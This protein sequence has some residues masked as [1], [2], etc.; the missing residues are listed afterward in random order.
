VYPERFAVG[1]INGDGNPDIIVTNAHVSSGEANGELRIVLGNGDGTFRPAQTHRFDKGI[2]DVVLADVNGDGRSD[3]IVANYQEAYVAVLVCNGDGTLQEGIRYAVEDFP[4]SIITADL[5]G[6]KK[7]D[8]VTANYGSGTLSIL[9]S[10]QHGG[11]VA[12]RLY[13]A[14]QYPSKVA[15]GDFNNDGHLDAVTANW[16]STNVSVFLSDGTGTLSLKATCGV[17]SYP[18][19]VAVG[20]FNRDR[21]LDIVTTNANGNSISV[22]TGNGDGTF[23]PE[24]RYPVGMWPSSVVVSDLNGDGWM[25]IVVTNRDVTP[26]ETDCTVSVLWN[27]QDGGFNSQSRLVTGS[28]P[29]SVAV[30]D[31]NRDGLRD[32]AVVN[33]GSQ[34]VSIFYNRGGQRFS[35]QRRY[36]VAS[37]PESLTVGDFNGDG[38]LD[39]VVA[40]SVG[41][42]FLLG[43]GDESFQTVEESSLPGS[44]FVV[45]ADINRD[46]HLDLVL[47][48]L[49]LMLG[50]GTGKFSLAG[51]YTV[52]ANA[53]A[54][55]DFDGDGW[56]DLAAS[57]SSG[58]VATL[59]NLL[60]IIDLGA[61][62][63]DLFSGFNATEMGST[64]LQ[65]TPVH[66]GFLTVLVGDVQV[67]G[68]VTLR[69]YDANPLAN[70]GAE[71]L[72]ETE[73]TS[74]RLEY[75]FV[76]GGRPYY[77]TLNG[78]DTDFSL[79]FVNLFGVKPLGEDGALVTIY[80]TDGDDTLELRPS[81][82]PQVVINGVLY[83]PHDIPASMTVQ[84]E[85]GAGY[86]VV[87]AYDGPG[88]D[89]FELRPGLLT[90][91][92]ETS[93]P[94]TLDA[95]MGFEQ[96]HVYATGG[97]QDTSRLY[98]KLSGGGVDVAVKLKSE[99][100]Y[101]HVK[102]IG[103]RM[104]HRVKLFEVVEAY[105]AGDN[106]QALFWDSTGDDLF[107][108]GYGSSRMIGPGYDVRAYNFPRVT[109]YASGGNDTAR[110]MDS[111]LKDEFQSKS[112][113]CELFD[114]VTGGSRY[115]VSVRA[116]DYVYAE[117]STA[118]SNRDAAKLWPTGGDDLVEISGNVLDFSVLQ[119][120]MPRLIRRV[121]G[122]ENAKLQPTA[123]SNDRVRLVEPV[124]MTVE[125]GT[126]WQVE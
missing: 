69:L 98:D 52:Q 15:V 113:K 57:V 63:D 27:D 1:D 18:S 74:T 70:P 80:G 83:S 111:V 38:N 73:G 115:R 58:Y 75:E 22:L 36:P 77:V 99:P 112:N 13:K 41:L 103:A 3:A 7:L 37:R 102:M 90:G 43:N 66:D 2:R 30:G 16:E 76:E 45:S 26:Y 93:V 10:D 126:G 6:D 95:V 108:G 109:A 59:I 107:E 49:R 28:M 72:A 117:A 120:G 9:I 39:V 55:G 65:V 64:V 92:L 89:L 51:K 71:P 44:S 94:I 122:F 4:S 82:T 104:Y 87:T 100:E 32:L 23:Q 88:N 79:R 48:G 119:T 106:D 17:G 60:N 56:M 101:K 118:G 20:D 47:P 50:D 46:G 125:I 5:N 62:D 54:V 25:D 61:V 14:G 81:P 97:G 85:L 33:F 34:D 105:A 96:A 123:G 31:F 114:Q 84:A 21:R 12:P 53:V 78:T 110:L 116:F 29:L 91:S 68:S 11:F 8:I 124:H 67:P 24:R 19:G 40:T 42:S 86:D 35:S 121:V